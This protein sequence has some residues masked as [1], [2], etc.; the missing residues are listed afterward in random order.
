MSKNISALSGRKGIDESLFEK[1]GQL[2]EPE[3][4]LTKEA[5]QKLL[6]KQEL[7]ELLACGQA[8]EVVRAPRYVTMYVPTPL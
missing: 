5:A 3:G 7:C 8:C 2:T 4:F 6:R 1:M